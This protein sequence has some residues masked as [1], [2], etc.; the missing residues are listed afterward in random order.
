M[1]AI[2]AVDLGGTQLRAG[3]A[4]AADPAAVETI[5]AWPA[6]ANLDAFADMLGGLIAEH[7]A[8]RLGCGI[9]G[10]A[11]GTVCAWV[12]N[13]GYLDGFDLAGL[14]PGLEVGLG[15]DAQLALLAEREAGAA[16]GM[17]DAL[18]LAIGTGIGSA[19]LAGGEIVRGS[20]GG[21]C[22]SAGR[23]PILPIP[24]TSVRA[25]SSGRPRAGR[26][27]RRRARAL[28]TARR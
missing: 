22:S 6:P 15:N 18:L 20:R 28:P 1:S 5:G 19:V 23:P 21:A 10:L 2:L 11:R 9:P 12:P 7:G 27:M 14:A 24:A 8:T 17:R 4:S 16:R 25:G 3:L 26:S 13:L